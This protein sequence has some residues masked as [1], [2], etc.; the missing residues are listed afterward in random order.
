MSDKNNDYQ[1]SSFK[2]YDFDLFS[3]GS[4]DQDIS[5]SSRHGGAQR[6]SR[7]GSGQRDLRS[8]SASRS[9][10]SSNQR[11]RV[12]RDVSMSG[13]PARK[14]SGNNNKRKRRKN[15]A[16]SMAARIAI[17]LL[18]VVSITGLLV[19][20]VFAVYVFSFVD[21]TLDYD[22]YDL[23][24]DY[25]TTIY[26][27]DDETGKYYELDTVHGNENRVW[28]N[29]NDCADVVYQA[30]IAAE[31]NTFETHGG[32]NWKRTFGAFANYFLHFWETEQGGSTITQQLV[33]NI[34]G[35]DDKSPMR[36]IQE[37]MRAR[38]VEGQYD[39]DV[40]LECYV[41]VIHYGN[42]CDGIQTAAKYYFN[43]DAGDL[44]L[45]EAASLAAT[46]KSPS[47][48]NPKRNP[49]N[50]E[51]R[52]EWVL[53]QM[54][55]LKYI[56][57]E[58][59]EAACKQD[60]QVY[61]GNTTSGSK[62][63]TNSY[64]VDYVLETVIAGLMEEEGCS[65]NAALSMINS[66][67]LKIYTTYSKRVQGAIDAVYADPSNFLRLRSQEVDPQSGFVVMDY[68][69]HVLGIMGGYGE[70]TADLLL[71]RAHQTIR[72]IGSTIKP[73]AAYSPAIETNRATWSTI[74]EDAPIKLPDGTMWPRNANGKYSGPMFLYDGLRRSI[75]TIA[76][77]LVDQ[78]SVQVAFDYCA[79]KY[80][81]STLVSAR[82]AANGKVQTDVALGPMGIGSLT[83][84]ATVVEMCAAYATFGNLGYYYQPTCITKVT[85]KSG[86]I[87]L[88]YDNPAQIAI[89]EDTASVMNKLL[90]NV[91]KSGTGAAGA[92]GGWELF[93]KT[94]TT[95][96]TKDL[97][98]CG[99]S[100][101]YVAACWYGYDKPTKMSG[102]PMNPALKVWKAVMAKAHEGLNKK[103]FPVSQDITYRYY[104]A[105]TGGLATDA[106]P[107]GQ[108]GW[109]KKSSLPATCTEHLKDGTVGTVLEPAGS[110][111]KPFEKDP[112]T[113]NST[114]STSSEEPVTDP[115]VPTE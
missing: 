74:I 57:Q 4:T 30:I 58:E 96:D 93:G 68:A 98:F 22:L 80:G 2:N 71:N 13:E 91:V 86:A 42:G 50:N 51:E 17:S 60:L 34:T 103:S 105:D 108:L 54:L 83:D 112:Q 70:K 52:R 72:P 62:G 47:N 100:P 14:P 99:G 35:D 76:V 55:D 6:S 41:N 75:N 15:K 53:K 11:R 1:A 38:Y 61:T 81:L 20:G 31:D 59:Y 102:L 63:A 26:A 115:I 46:I 39:K 23:K 77:R 84:G 27:P 90:Q 37:I 104:C 97:W 110:G 21:G 48:Y 19:V 44:T 5:S 36:K 82:T 8:N 111:S 109:Y 65:R 56:T 43:K 106:C 28:V 69:G 29:Y 3:S 89:S 40:I 10:A 45:L 64:Y 33:K 66:D 94:G 113:G 95:S 16:L 18:L 25:N 73:L 67:G 79:N 88:E 12:A 49:K 32:I 114:G 9:S 101:Y 107:K 92:F 87:L 7:S 85:S 78:I 24:I